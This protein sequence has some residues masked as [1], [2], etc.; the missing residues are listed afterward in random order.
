MSWKLVITYEETKQRHTAQMAKHKA[1]WDR[2]G[3][4]AT[5]TFCGI[6]VVEG[7]VFSE[8]SF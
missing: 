2:T 6:E 7:A 1:I 8:I 4:G 5:G 3:S